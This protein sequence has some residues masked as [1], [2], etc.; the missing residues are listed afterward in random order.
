[1][2]TKD[3]VTIMV[4]AYRYAVGRMTYAPGLVCDYIAGKIPEMSD[5]QIEDLIDEVKKTIQYQDYADDIALNEV[6]KLF[7][8][9]RRGKQEDE[10]N[11]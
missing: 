6:N 10:K 2:L 3:D 4:F 8:R 5:R 7:C 9:L 1:M 11:E